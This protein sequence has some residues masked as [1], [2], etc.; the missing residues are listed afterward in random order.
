MVVT[1]AEFRFIVTEQLAGD[2][3]G[4]RRGADRARGAQH[5]PRG[6]RR[7]AAASP[8][9]DPDGADAGL[10]LGPRHPRRRG[11]PRRGARRRGRGRGR[12]RSSPSACARR[13]PRP[14]TAISSSPTP[15]TAAAPPAPLPLRRFVEK[16][17][18]AT[19]AAMLAGGRHLWNSGVFLFSA[20]AIIE[21]FETHQPAMLAAVRAAVAGG[22]GRPRL[23]AARPGGLG[24]VETLSIDYAVMEKAGEPR[25]R[26][27]RRRLVGPRLLGR[28]RPRHG[29]GRDRHG[30]LGP[31]ARR[32]TAR[33]ACCAPR[34]PT[35]CWSASG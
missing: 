18:A 2:R 17:D 25:R 27:L 32:S 34:A 8:R 24:R 26:A 12:R 31:G 10:P 35:R 6:A 5:R 15:P 9:R 33:T 30:A 16:P 7:G 23:P 19:A 3:P 11:L 1:G 14:A 13:G 21:A 22:D 4:A 20:A 29:D 28:H